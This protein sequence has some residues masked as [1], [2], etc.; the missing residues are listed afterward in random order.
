[1]A[2]NS[3]EKLVSRLAV[4]GAYPATMV[5][6]FALYVAFVGVGLPV[7][8][9]SFASVLIGA[10]LITL[11]EIKLPN[12]EEW[13]PSAAEVRTDAVFMVTVQV[14][15]PY[16]LSVTLVIAISE[17]LRTNGFIIRDYWPHDLSVAAQACSQSWCATSPP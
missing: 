8:L 10:A 9:A 15:L 12:R 4:I 1:M 11:H 3:S 17:Y 6:G 2:D 13:R 5:L 16:L 7:T 14:A